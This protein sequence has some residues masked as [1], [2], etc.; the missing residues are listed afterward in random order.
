MVSLPSSNISDI[1][2]VELSDL[3]IIS[4]PA[5]TLTIEGGQENLALIV[6]YSGQ[7]KVVGKDLNELI[8]NLSNPAKIPALESG[9]E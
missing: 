6:E 3:E 1:P 4:E 2:R 8:A 5:K 9:E 7:F